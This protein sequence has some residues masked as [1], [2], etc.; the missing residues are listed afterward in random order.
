MQASW[1]STG[2]IL[3]PSGSRWESFFKG[4][5]EISFSWPI[6]IDFQPFGALVWNDFYKEHDADLHADCS[7]T[8]RDMVTCKKSWN[9][10]KTISFG[11]F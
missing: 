2:G 1:K 6:V 3:G 11:N 9:I 4:P 5:V 10:V 8:A 7:C